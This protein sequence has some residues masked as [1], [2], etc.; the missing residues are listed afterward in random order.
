MHQDSFPKLGVCILTFNSALTIGHVLKFLLM[1]DYPKDKVF[2]LIVDGGSSDNSLEIVYSVFRDYPG[3]KFEVLVARDTN[4]PQARNVC[5]EK[6]LQ[7][8]VDY[9]LFVDS[10]T[11]VTA[12]NAFKVLTQISKEN[13]SLVYL[14][15]T[16]K[17]F[18]DV[19]EL[20]TF[21]NE[22]KPKEITITSNDLIPSFKISMGFTII[23]KG[24]VMQQKFDEDLDTS[25][26]FF[27]A[28]K[29]FSRGYTPLKSISPYTYDLNL[30]GEQGDIYWIASFKKYLRCMKKKAVARLIAWTEDKTLRL[31][32]KE[33]LKGVT[34]HL[35]NTL[36]LATL[37]LL[38]VLVLVSMSLFIAALT[39][40]LSSIL[41]YAIYKKLR[42][43]EIFGSIRNRI[44][45]ELYSALL[46]L[47]LP[48]AYREFTRSLSKHALPQQRQVY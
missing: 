16:F 13:N 9:I 47:N 3:L 45:F 42:G 35:I 30:K 8:D 21:I 1:E 6:L 29:A 15:T 32:R 25:E 14:S 18:R 36:L 44:K 2:Y 7:V 4:I 46:I 17:Y 24:L 38:P 11:I 10:D 28:F 5:L 37:F 34:R 19:E 41:G 27:Y 40:R 39:A 22:L 31:S 33:I 20:Q 23:P 26:D 12:T 43:Y 48:T